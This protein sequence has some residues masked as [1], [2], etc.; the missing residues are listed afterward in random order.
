[1]RVALRCVA[2]GWRRGAKKPSTEKVKFI[3]EQ[4]LRGGGQSG[5]GDHEEAKGFGF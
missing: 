4:D 1:M 3:G 2:L 5:V